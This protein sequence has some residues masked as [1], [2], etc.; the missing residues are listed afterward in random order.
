MGEGC[1]IW[2]QNWQPTKSFKTWS[3]GRP[4]TFK[5]RSERFHCWCN[6]LCVCVCARIVSVCVK[7][8]HNFSSAQWSF[9]LPFHRKSMSSLTESMELL[10][11]FW[12]AQQ[13]E[14]V[15]FKSSRGNQ[16]HQAPVGQENVKSVYMFVVVFC[17]VF[18][19]AWGPKT[20]AVCFKC[21][22]PSLK[23]GTDY[24][25]HPISHFFP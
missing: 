18:V 20:F 10:F 2:K 4:R 1:P 9:Q 3:Q 13:W 11:A 8:G 25:L 7:E 23:R 24:F 15:P 14:K 5:I 19:Y 6:V 21:F 16:T 22:L 12:Q 17:F